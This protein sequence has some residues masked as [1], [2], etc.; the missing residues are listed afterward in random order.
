[1]KHSFN[2]NFT[3]IILLLLLILILILL[4]LISLKKHKKTV[5]NFNSYKKI[6]KQDFNT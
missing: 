3:L 1:M 6:K 4:K 5:E 2:Y